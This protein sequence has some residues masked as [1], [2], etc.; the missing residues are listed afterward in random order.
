MKTVLFTFAGAIFALFCT[1]VIAVVFAPKEITVVSTSRVK[2]PL[3]LVRDNVRFF[4]RYPSWSPWLEQDPQQQYRVEG[5]DGAVGVKYH[6]KGVAEK[7]LGFQTLTTLTENSLA[8]RCD[9]SE[10]FTSTPDFSYAFSEENGETLIT[11]TFVTA[12]SAPM[13][14]IGMLMGL[15]K[16]IRKVNERGLE[17]LKIFTEKNTIALENAH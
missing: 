12:M 6:W 14:A 11:Q 5:T 1:F 10:P 9:I 7:G 3:Q 17:R 8:I 15:E 2:A 16:N 4:S 13:N